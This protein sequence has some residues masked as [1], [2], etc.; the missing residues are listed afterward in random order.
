MR[1]IFFLPVLF[2]AHYKKRINKLE[3][4]GINLKIIGFERNHYADKSWKYPT[5]SIGYIEHGKYLSR[6]PSFIKSIFIMHREVKEADVLYCFNIETLFIGWL[7]LL[8]SS[9]QTKLVYDVADIREIF[10]GSNLLSGILRKVESFLVKKTEVVVVTSP[11]YI[12]GYFHGVLGL[13][14]SEFYVIENKLDANTPVKHN[15]SLES[16]ADVY[17]NNQVTIG[18][19]G[20]IRCNHSLQVLN[21]LADKAAGKIKIYIRGIFMDTEKLKE[22]ILQSNHVEFGGPFVSPVDLADMYKKIDISWLAQYH[23]KTNVK[24]ARTNRF[25]Q[26]CFFECPMITQVGTQDYIQMKK[27]DIGCSVD[28]T[29]PDQAINELL[30]LS[31]VDIKKWKHNISNVPKTN[32][33]YSDE[34]KLLVQKLS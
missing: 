24:W 14:S 33:T 10:V 26:A 3:E 7:S 20:I 16:G 6:I 21:Q 22:I 9:S 17:D 29:K 23:Y 13:H 27:F 5:Q 34:H 32:Y 12:E 8:F 25:Y 15:I 30:N 2:D 31:K 18:Y 4:A 19:F 1:F 11:D 28:L